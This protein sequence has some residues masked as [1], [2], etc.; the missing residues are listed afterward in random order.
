MAA[1]LPLGVV[2]V[3]DGNGFPL[4]A[5]TID[6]F[7]A[8]SST[9]KTTW[10]IADK[11][12]AN[13]NPIVLDSAGRAVI[14]GDGVYRLLV[15]DAEGNTVWDQPS[16]TLVSDAMAPV[17]IAPTIADALEA[18]GVT[19]AIATAVAAEAA[20]RAT[21]ITSV[22]T[23][24]TAEAN[25]RIAADTDIQTA[26]TAEATNRIAQVAAE[27]VLR[28]AG[29]ANLQSQIDTGTALPPGMVTQT[30]SSTSNG[31]GDFSVTLPVPYAGNI[32]SFEVSGT[33][34]RLST[35]SLAVGA[36]PVAT[37]TG[38][39]WQDVGLADPGHLALTT[40]FN[41]VAEGW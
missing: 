10:T 35:A 18:L 15:K 28:A 12:A 39:L 11:S 33:G 41:W 14:Y 4:A 20:A 6:T 21:D 31:S 8:N 22:Q 27:A 24:L 36:P 2:Q 37:V 19:D 3:C 30:G 38:E 16:N 1:L 34:T 29:D 17:I 5:G 23:A 40:A 13:S 9:P 26:L 7:V 25:A 32:R